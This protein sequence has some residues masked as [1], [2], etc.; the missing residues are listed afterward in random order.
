M[1]TF[2]EEYN[3]DVIRRS[4][5]YPQS[6]GLDEVAVKIAKKILDSKDP[7]IALLMYRA[8]P[9]K[10]G[11]SPAELLMI[12]QI[13]CT[14]PR[15]ELKNEIP[16]QEEVERH[17]EINKR[18]MEKN[19]N[20]SARNLDKLLP[21]TRVFVDAIQQRGNIVSKRNEPRSYNICLDNGGTI[22]QNHRNLQCP[23]L[24][25]EAYAE[26]I[27]DYPVETKSAEETFQSANVPTPPE[28]REPKKKPSSK[29]RK[30][31]NSPILTYGLVPVPYCTRTG[32]GVMQPERALFGTDPRSK[33]F[34][35]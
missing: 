3:V 9:T 5:P 10:L 34:S 4:P 27:D 2:S 32:R 24:Y 33:I 7:N 21:G 28:S 8:T 25:Q 11:Y 1:T 22:R 19:Y 18:H 23:K 15:I 6:N 35:P 20:K 29:K 30:N 14:N 12:R 26:E 16:P 17:Y 31:R 13:R